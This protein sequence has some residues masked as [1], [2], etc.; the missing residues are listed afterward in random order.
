MVSVRGL[1]LAQDAYGYISGS[2]SGLQV[3]EGAYQVADSASVNGVALISYRLTF[4]KEVYGYT[5]G[6]A[7]WLTGSRRRLSP[8][9]AHLSGLASY[10][11]VS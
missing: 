9:V 2:L 1:Q 4:T 11:A 6:I 5:F 3:T 8:P 10:S 7:K